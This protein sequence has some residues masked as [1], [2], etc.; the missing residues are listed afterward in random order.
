MTDITSKER[1][2]KWDIAVK[3]FDNDIIILNEKK[4]NNRPYLL[5]KCP[6]CGKERWILK[7]HQKRMKN[8][9][10][11]T[12]VK[13]RYTL[14]YIDSE[15]N[16]AYFYVKDK[17][18]TIKV[19]V[20]YEIADKLFGCS[21]GISGK[22]KYVVIANGLGKRMRLTSFILGYEFDDKKYVPDHKNHNIY[23]N[24]K[25]NLILVEQ[26]LNQAN[27][28]MQSNNVSGFRGIHWDNSNNKWVV[29]V[30][31]HRKHITKKRFN[32]FIDA[33]NHWYEIYHRQ[34]KEH[35]Y[36]IF[37]D[38]TKTLRYAK[39]EH[40]DVQ[41][42]VGI[43]YTLFVQG[44]SNHC[45]GCFNKS[46]WDFDRGIKYTKDVFDEMVNFFNKFPQVKRLTLCGGEPLQNLELS[47][48]ISA[49]FKRLFPE[50]NLW[51]YTGL[52]FEDI[53]DDIKYKAILELCDVLVDGRFIESQKDLS[54]K[55]RGSRNQRIIDVP[56]TLEE[57]KIILYDE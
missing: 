45:V 31:F 32:K 57:G 23:D 15:L 39:V 30:K 21:F 28:K 16:C 3:E 20:D 6:H 14:F 17:E 55:F 4:I 22:E 51:I 50:R 10:C 56:K 40:F 33:Y 48:F 25:Q 46:T 24:R 26:T 18:N 27:K 19:L 11:T 41:N 1:I 43:G 47:N 34:Y 38:Q 42:G 36:S 49:E 54:L 12:C 44:C 8:T 37:R 9:L 7:D 52:S 13:R 35:A 29:Q 53:K 5:I 2:K